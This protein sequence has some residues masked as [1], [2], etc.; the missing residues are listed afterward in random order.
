MISPDG[1]FSG[2]ESYILLCAYREPTELTDG[3]S[4]FTEG[5]RRTDPE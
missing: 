4:G 2:V 1:R 3:G 5:T